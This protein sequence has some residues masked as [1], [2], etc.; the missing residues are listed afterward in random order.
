MRSRRRFGED[1]KEGGGGKRNFSCSHTLL[2]FHLVGGGGGAGGGKEEKT[3]LS[4]T[5]YSC[6]FPTGLFWGEGSMHF[7]FA[8]IQHEK[9]PATMTR[10]RHTFF[11]FPQAEFVA[12]ATLQKSRREGGKKVSST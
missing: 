10:F 6:C 3:A 7:F 1:W 8:E 12:L 5:K 2:A 4:H 11:F 9:C